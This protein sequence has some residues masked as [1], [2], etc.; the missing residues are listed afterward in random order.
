MS[1]DDTAVH[2]QK[3]DGARS[4]YDLLV[5]TDLTSNDALGIP[6]NETCPEY[7]A[8]SGTVP[9]SSLPH[10][11]FQ[12]TCDSIFFHVFDDI[13]LLC[14]PV[15]LRTPGSRSV[16]HINWVWCRNLSPTSSHCDVMTDKNGKVHKNSIPA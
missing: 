4:Q 5:C 3:S 13:H 1:Q 9:L 10:E 2:V 8:R 16:S 11:C 7:F 15:L 12:S 6:M 14:S